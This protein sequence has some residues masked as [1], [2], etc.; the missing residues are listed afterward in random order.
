MSNARKVF[1]RSSDI[2][3]GQRRNEDDTEAGAPEHATV[4]FDVVDPTSPTAI[5]YYLDGAPN[6]ST[7][8]SPRSSNVQEARVADVESSVIN[9]HANKI[10]RPVI[11]KQGSSQSLQSRAVGS[12]T[13]RLSSLVV[14]KKGSKS[15]VKN[16]AVETL[17][18]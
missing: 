16:P 12:V 10:E 8:A 7:W 17:A 18:E 11:E 5:G 14:G 15:S 4:S 3:V 9:R 2:R 13:R 1:P 6:Q